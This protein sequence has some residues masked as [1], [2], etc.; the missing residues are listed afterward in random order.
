MIESGRA[1]PA[2]QA[3]RAATDRALAAHPWL[4]ELRAAPWTPPGP[5][6][7]GADRQTVRELVRRGLVVER[8]GVY[9]ATEA[10]DQAARTIAGLL[11]GSP[12]GVS[13][14]VIR[15]ALGTTRK[16]VLPLL[17]ELDA[18]GVTRRRGD[19]RIGGPRLPVAPPDGAPATQARE[20]PAGP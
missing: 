20:P 19:L 16:F 18:T 5:E 3:D 7:A 15:D 9:F 1:W 13:V 14:S 10:V 8:D 11:A 4:A 17:A 12:D 2:G 6:T